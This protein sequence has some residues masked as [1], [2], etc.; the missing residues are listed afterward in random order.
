M[1]RQIWLWSCLLSLVLILLL[2]CG[3]GPAATPSPTTKAPPSPTAPGQTTKPA[4]SPTSAAISFAGRT[5]TIVLPYTAG[6]G[7]DV[8]AR[9]YAMYLPKWLPGKP[10]ML[11]RNMPGGAGS[12]G[13][14]H[15]Y[16][17]KPDGMTALV[18]SGS[19]H[20]YPLA[21]TKSHRYDLLKMPTIVGSPTGGVF[22]VKAGVISKPEDAPKAKGLV[23]GYSTGSGAW[24]F[25]TA[26]ELL[27][28]PVDKVILAYGGESDAFRAFLAGEVNLSFG[29][30][31]MYQ[32]SVAPFVAKGEVMP[33]FQTGLLDEKGNVIKEPGLPADIPTVKEVY[34]KIYGKSPSG[35]AWDAYKAVVAAGRNYD[36]VMFLTPGTPDEIVKAYWAAAEAMIKDSQFLAT[37]APLAGKDTRWGAGEAYQKEFRLNYGMKPEVRDWFRSILPK[38]G[39]V[40]E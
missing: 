16:S 25:P 6:G 10:G 35:M 12:I 3:P 20:L 21:G 39:V 11:V 19:V 33:L 2:A 26:K 4:P 17:A 15:V 34:E 32:D 36:R 40:V 31:T 1:K 5:I 24:I 27:N 13:S 29:T 37:M 8:T 28:L 23:F 18:S 22:Y 30:T 38:Y 9:V 7:T 14:N